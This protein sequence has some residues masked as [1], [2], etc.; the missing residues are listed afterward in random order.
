MDN[1][2]Q[3]D[4]NLGIE[5]IHK[6]TL[7][8]SCNV[9]QTRLT[10]LTAQEVENSR[11]KHGQNTITKKKE[12]STIRIFL[13]NFISLMAILLW[14]AGAIAIMAD[15]PELGIAIW[16]V[17][18]INGVFSFWQEFRA[19]KATEALKSMLPSYARVVR[20]GDRKCRGFRGQ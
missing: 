8:E 5:T 3:R 18:I 4:Q 13:V 14:F 12:K 20:D 2:I 16:L 1:D 9:M 10:G 11:T 7:S 17:N 19:N 6:L 15:M